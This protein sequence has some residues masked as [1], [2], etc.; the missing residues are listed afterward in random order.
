[1]AAGLAIGGGAAWYVSASVR[2]LLFQVQPTDGRVFALAI[3]TL[4]LAGLAASAIPARRAARVDP[5]V[6]LRRE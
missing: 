1:M 2:S 6:A 5:L 4:S 3:T